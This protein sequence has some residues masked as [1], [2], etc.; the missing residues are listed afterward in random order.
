VLPA[1]DRGSPRRNG[2]GAVMDL[3]RR[4]CYA[5]SKSVGHVAGV[6]GW[7]KSRLE[8]WRTSA[9]LL[10]HNNHP[11]I[12]G[13]GGTIK[14]IAVRSGFSW[15]A[16]RDV[17]QHFRMDEGENCPEQDDISVW[18]NAVV[19]SLKSSLRC[20]G[21]AR[22]RCRVGWASAA[23]KADRCRGHAGDRIKV[24][25]LRSP[26]EERGRGELRMRADFFERRR[27]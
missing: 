3:V 11:Q 14:T 7:L 17:C 15:H 8:A 22:R 21:R 23:R 24:P 2:A 6:R 26:T 5:R 1:G 9:R 10:Q 18:S 27:V 13:T 20:G 12:G 19:C 25:P 16:E 4:R